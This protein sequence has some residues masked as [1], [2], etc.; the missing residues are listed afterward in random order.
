MSCTFYIE[1]FRL[2]SLDR[3]QLRPHLRARHPEQDGLSS[4]HRD[5]GA[6]LLYLVALLVG[7]VEQLLAGSHRAVRLPAGVDRRRAVDHAQPAPDSLPLRPV[8][9][10]AQFPPHDFSRSGP[11][12]VRRFLPRRPL[13][14]DILQ[15]IQP[16]LPLLHVFPSL[17]G[18]RLQR[19]FDQQDVDDGGPRQS[20]AFLA[21]RPEHS[22]LLRL[23][24]SLVSPGGHYS[25][26][27]MHGSR[28][29]LRSLHV[30][31]AY[32]SSPPS[33]GSG[34]RARRAPSLCQYLR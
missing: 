21:S 3:P 12:L 15:S 11:R 29:L 6:P 25:S 23:R 19:L 9:D 34:A 5:S 8:V 28:A 30:L 2:T 4:V 13:Q 14:F 27:P 20:S 10:A 16:R 7:S 32:V 31:N 24:R 33:F 18:R 26:S 17:A 22:A 1:R